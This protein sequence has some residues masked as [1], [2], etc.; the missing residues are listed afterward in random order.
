MTAIYKDTIQQYNLQDFVSQ[1]LTKF[2]D[3]IQDK[4][5]FTNI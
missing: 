5:K 3:E 1:M 4:I 2:E